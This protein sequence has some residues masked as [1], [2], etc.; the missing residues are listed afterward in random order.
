MISR[1]VRSGATTNAASRRTEPDPAPVPV[2][3]GELA[4]DSELHLHALDTSGRRLSHAKPLSGDDIDGDLNFAKL[5]SDGDGTPELYAFMDKGTKYYTGTPRIYRLQ[6][7]G[8]L[9]LIHRGPENGAGRRYTL[10]TADPG[11]TQGSER[12]LVYWKK[13]QRIEL[14]DLEGDGKVLLRRS[15]ARKRHFFAANLD[16]DAAWELLEVHEGELLVESLDGT[17][18][19]RI[20][21]SVEDGNVHVID[22]DGNGRQ[23]VVIRGGGRVEI[24]GY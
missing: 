23:E 10:P 3:D 5:D 9:E 22:I 6:E 2:P 13:L 15:V 4:R 20:P 18:V 1:S 19:A 11:A 16:G 7:S 17:Q 21:V 24:L 14:L 12:L 8:A